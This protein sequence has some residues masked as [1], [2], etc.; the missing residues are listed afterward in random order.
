MQYPGLDNSLNSTYTEKWAFGYRYYHLHNEQPRFWFGEGM[1]YADFGLVAGSLTWDEDASVSVKIIN[2]GDVAGT[3][4]PQLYLALPKACD[5]PMW[6]LKGIEKV[7]LEAGE[8]ATVTFAL[9]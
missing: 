7:S 5:A 4:T 1:S 8:A 2:N 3:S 9:T 6:M